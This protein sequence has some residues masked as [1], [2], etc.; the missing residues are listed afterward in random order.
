MLPH[1]SIVSS[2]FVFLLFEE[3]AEHSL[4]EG[5]KVGFDSGNGL[6]A[7]ENNSYIFGAEEV[8]RFFGL[9]I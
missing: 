4:L 6:I 1:V 8:G 7:A 9:Y 5:R 3:I 2:L